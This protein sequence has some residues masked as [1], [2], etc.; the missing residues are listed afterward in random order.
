[1]TLPRSV[2]EAVLAVEQ[3]ATA[4]AL[5][6][7]TL[8]FKTVGRSVS[9]TEVD[10]AEAAACFANALGGYLVVGVADRARGIE[11]LV[12]CTLDVDRLQRRIYDVTTPPLIV[13]VEEQVW[14]DRRLVVV[15][16]PRSPDVHQVRGRATER[17]STSCEPMSAARIAAVVAERRGDDWSTGGSDVPVG[18]VAPQAI[19]EVKRLLS[20]APDAERRR[21]VALSQADLVRRLGLGTPEGTLTRAGVLLLVHG[22][23]PSVAYVHRRTR[24]GELTTNTELSGAGLTVLLRSLELIDAHV[25]RTPVNLPSGQQLLIADLPDLAVREAVVNAFIHRDHQAGGVVQIEHSSTRLAVTSPGSF[26]LGVSPQNILTVSSRSRNTSL[27]RAVRTLTLAESAG[28]GVDRMY[29]EMVRVGHQPPVWDAD[30]FRVTVTLNGGAPNSSVTR[31]A[32]TLPDGRDGDPDTLLVML[33]LL[34]RRTTTA[35][36]MSPVVQK[37]V[38][39]VEVIL[40]ELATPAVALIERTRESTNA[41]SGVYRLRDAALAALGPAVAY[42]RRVGD[43]TDR[44]VVEIVRETGSVNGRIVRTLLDVDAP[45]ASRVLADLVSRGLLVKTSQAQR[46]PSV[47]YGPG[48]QFPRGPRRRARRQP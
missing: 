42:R 21:W 47:A 40:Q 1:M 33:T 6:S 28:V 22:D 15:T 43:D 39:E 7:A 19:E 30:P 23:Q 26:V 46:G 5:E 18:E 13:T 17:V 14:A 20:R 45:T 12:G 37:P 25:D 29:A 16:V 4:S 9:D 38:D 27:T 3:G 41:R 31:F 8:D 2:G 11:A 44:K 35:A 48:P 34:T 10:L 32:A 24:S 36:A